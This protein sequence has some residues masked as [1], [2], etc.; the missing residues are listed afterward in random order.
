M[1]ESEVWGELSTL[2]MN[3]IYDIGRQNSVSDYII[4][5]NN[6]AMHTVS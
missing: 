1:Y 5:G 2:K 4:Q 3:R 6:Y